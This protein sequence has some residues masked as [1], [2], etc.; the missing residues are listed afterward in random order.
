MSEIPYHGIDSRPSGN[1]QA[2]V[3]AC[4][5]IKAFHHAGEELQLADIT[6]RT[7]LRRTTAFRLLQSLVHGGLLE[8]TARGVYRCPFSPAPGWRFRLGFAA[9]TDSE[10]SSGVTE[11]LQR[12]AARERVDLIT[13]N[14][15]YSPKE[16]LRN[17][18]LL[19]REHVDLVL[20]FQTYERV[21]PIVAAKFLEARIPVI[22]I[23][24][25]HPGAIY[26]GANNYQAGLIAGRTLGRWAKENWDGAVEHLMLLELPIAGPLLGLRVTGIQDGL[27][28]EL[29]RITNTPT[30]HL[31]GR[32]DFDQI[33]LA[34]RRW[35]RRNPRRRTLVGTVNDMCA[36]AALRAFEEAGAGHL[37][38]VVGQNA[39]HDA[40]NELRRP[41]TRLIGTVAYFPERYGDELLPLA[42]SVLERKPVPPATFV[43]HQLLTP[44]N[45]NLIYP[46]DQP[47][48][49]PSTAPKA[50]TR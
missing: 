46:L 25:P 36:L 14:N 1:V 48:N 9:Q 23:E 32:G 11:S 33:L 19:I 49:M 45:V 43:K 41:G 8:R 42:L 12:A 21:A 2:V 37:C 3:R 47:G 6:K 28:S 31:D 20:E 15:R 26:F 7:A 18:D 34:V 30:V 22:A 13:V 24:I 40:R 38:A 50:R 17:A 16:A 39:I 27:R 29:P 4:D 5:I 35:L 44:K 10:F